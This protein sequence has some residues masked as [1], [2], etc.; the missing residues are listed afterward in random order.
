[1]NKKLV[2]ICWLW[3]IATL[4]LGTSVAWSAQVTLAWDANTPAPDGYRLYRRTQS[5]L[6]NYNQPVWSGRTATCTLTDLSAATQYYLVVRAYTGTTESGDSNEIGYLTSA[7]TTTPT[8]T[9]TPTATP[10][11]T[12]TPTATPTPTAI[13]K[14]TAT[15][16][17][18]ATPKPTAIPTPTPTATPKPTTTPTATPAPTAA[19]KPTATPTP[20]TTPTPIPNQA[21]VAEA[22]DSQTVASGEKVTLNGTKSYDPDGQAITYKWIQTGGTSVALSAATVSKPTFTAPTVATGQSVTLVFELTVTDSKALAAVDT[23]LV[24]VTGAQAVDRD[25]DGVPDN[26]D[27]FPDDATRWEQNLPPSPPAIM[28]PADGATSIDLTPVL[29]ASAFS[30]ANAADTHL[31]SEWRIVSK[32]NQKTV[33][34]VTRKGYYLTYYRVPHLVLKA[35]SEYTCQVRYFDAR[36][37]ASEWSLASA[38]T[39]RSSSYARSSASPATDMALTDLNA[40]G[41]T[42]AQETE[43][44]LSIAT[45]DDKCALALSIAEAG[46]QTVSIDDLVSVDPNTEEP[47][48]PVQDIGSYGVIS[49]CLQV[50]QPGQE[51][52]V[53]L[54]FSEP[55]DPQATWLVQGANG[56]LQE[57]TGSGVQPEADGASAVRLLK[58]GGENDID[59][60][61]NGTIIDVVAPRAVA[62][63]APQA[64]NQNAALDANSG[65]SHSSASGSCFISSLLQ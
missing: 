41:I 35:N 60:V 40:N 19:P 61:A 6:Y 5:Q 8:P 31:K 13:P 17:P 63:D 43:T 37:A 51:V 27:A 10:R 15:P 29:Y 44:L 55:I 24:Q 62:S 1:M 28:Y 26:Q 38:F 58:D 45:Y 21:P 59:G 47:S 50:P 22:G 7:T 2:M 30:D 9:A 42:D 53:R 3:V 16:A 11:P 12:A 14:A 57:S 33:L 25:G 65:G 46:E 36:E 20:T 18:T 48:P 49:Y 32:K 23:C 64:P 52:S 56:V 4:L 34:Q 54:Y 39:T